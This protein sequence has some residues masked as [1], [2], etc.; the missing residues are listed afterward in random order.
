MGEAFD[1]QFASVSAGYLRW[2]PRYP[3]RLFEW[4]AATAGNRRDLA[5]DCATGNGQA[6]I[7]LAD[8]FTR[9]IATD[10]STHQLA[11]AIAH[12]R[13][14]Y[15]QAPAEASGL[16]AGTVDAVTVAQA[17]HWLPRDAFYAEARRVLKPG[18]LIV[19]WGY[20]LPAIGVPDVDR[21]IREF[22]DSIV[23]PYWKAGRQL[24]VDRFQTID[25]PFDDVAAPEFNIRRNLTLGEF[26]QF[27]RTQSATARYIEV[28]GEDPVPA[29]E[30]AVRTAWGVGEQEVRWPIFVRAGVA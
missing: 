10:A 12:P 22:H 7:G 24:V 19:A 18:G 4:I 26:G 16:D 15:R 2:R 28:R 5:W 27:L 6:A 17:L 1:D 29:F 25:F 20:H 13:V 3:R 8:D 23:G 21:R 11:H 9:V 14:T 30:Q